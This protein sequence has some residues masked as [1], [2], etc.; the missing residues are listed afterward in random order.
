[1]AASS[2]VQVRRLTEFEAGDRIGHA[3]A[4]EKGGLSRHVNAL[5]CPLSQLGGVGR[6]SCVLYSDGTHLNV[7]SYVYVGYFRDAES[8][9]LGLDEDFWREL[10]EE[11]PEGLALPLVEA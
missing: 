2:R 5:S 3:C 10:G 4:V 11:E 9:R 6:P 8:Q 7:M 1:M